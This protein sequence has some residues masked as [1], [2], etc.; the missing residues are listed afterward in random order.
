MQVQRL[1]LKLKA[2]VRGV[3]PLV[4]SMARGP[5]RHVVFCGNWPVILIYMYILICT[6]SSHW[7][8]ETLDVDVG[9]GS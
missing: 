5:L 2:Y 7:S 6:V 1:E 9:P 8:P 4:F 3:V